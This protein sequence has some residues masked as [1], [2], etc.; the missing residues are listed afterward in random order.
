MQTKK[1][2]KRINKNKIIV[3]LPFWS[4]EKI[5]EKIGEYTFDSVKEYIPQDFGYIYYKYSEDLINSDPRLTRKYFNKLISEIS[6][7]IKKI[8]GKKN[9]KEFYI[10]A[11]SLGGLFAMIISDKVNIKKISLICPGDNL[12]ECFWNGVATQKIKQKMKE[13]GIKKDELKKIW[14]KISPDYYFKNKSKKTKFYIEL[15][16]KDKVIPYKN[17]NNLVRLL[18]ER[19][20]NFEINKNALSHEIALMEE[21]PL[22]RRPLNFL[23]N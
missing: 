23:L 5:K 15:S 17:G 10:F 13:N 16:K 21:G 3:L 6:S 19:R 1:E 4:D 20:I 22:F 11:Q 14:L 2:T 8:Q 18:K 9:K 7:D 12:A